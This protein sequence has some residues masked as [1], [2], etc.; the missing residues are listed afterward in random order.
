MS[1]AITRAR[2][3]D[4][5][6]LLLAAA[7]CALVSACR[8]LP[9]SA[10]AADLG[11]T[12][13]WPQ[14]RALLQQLQSYECAGRVAVSAPGQGFNAQFV[15]RQSG[16][17]AQLN[18]RGPL[19][20]GG[21]IVTASGP[22]LALQSTDGRQF[23]GDAARAELE[24]AIG[25]PLPVAALGRWLLGVPQPQDAATETIAPVISGQP[26]QLSALEQQG[27]RVEYQPHGGV[28]RLITLTAG[29]TRV[30]LVVDRWEW[31]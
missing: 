23:D 28:P 24:R 7:T 22:R 5:A 16:E 15:W 9:P 10:P 13:A 26:A 21:L 2:R 20:A 17:S 14:R 11:L 19:G 25:A 30:R 27:W 18:L 1:V 29:Q 8:T 3:R 6:A 12:A 31:L 4:A